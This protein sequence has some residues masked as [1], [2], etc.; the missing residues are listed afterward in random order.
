MGQKHLTHIGVLADF[1]AFMLENQLATE[2]DFR[3][4]QEGGRSK[5]LSELVSQWKKE[6]QN[7]NIQ[8]ADKIVEAMDD[9]GYST[10][11][12]KAIATRQYRQMDT[13]QHE[14]FVRF[15]RQYV[16]ALT[17]SEI[18]K[19]KKLEDFSTKWYAKVR[20]AKQVGLSE[21]SFLMAWTATKNIES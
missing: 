20:G 3:N 14:D 4:I 8:A 16:G 11:R 19:S 2:Q 13:E 5:E 18:D 6:V 9:L 12:Y 7:G 10:R 1:K 21:E 15:T 17:L